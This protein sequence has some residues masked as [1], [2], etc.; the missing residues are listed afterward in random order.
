MPSPITASLG[1]A[2]AQVPTPQP[3]ARVES[4]APLPIPQIAAASQAASAVTS[5]TY[6]P[7]KLRTL[8]IPKKVEGAFASQEIDAESKGL[9]ESTSEAESKPAG[10]RES[11]Q[12]VDIEA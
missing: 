2:L 7:D 4:P 1:T 3:A 11:S 12:R 10:E 6:R 5:V 9:R 8:Q